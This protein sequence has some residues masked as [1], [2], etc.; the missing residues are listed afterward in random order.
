MPTTISFRSSEGF[1]VCAEEEGHKPLNCTRKFEDNIPQSW[2]TFEL[3]KLGGNKVALKA[4]NGKYVRANEGGNSFLI[5]D[6]D[7]ANA[8]EQF[9]LEDHGGRYALRTSDGYYWCAEGGGGGELH[10][11]RTEVGG[12]WETFTLVSTAVI[13]EPP[14]VGGRLSI[15]GRYFVNDFGLYRWRFV[16]ALS[17]LAKPH[18]QQ[19]EYLDWVVNTGFNGIRVFAGALTWAGQ[20]AAMAVERL[21]RLLE[22][23]QARGLYVEI[24]AITDSKEGGYNVVEHATVIGNIARAFENTTLELANEPFHGTQADALRDIKFLR[25]LS[26]AVPSYVCTAFGASSDDENDEFAEGDYITVH[27]DRGRDKWNQ[28]RRVREMLALSE[29][30]KKPVVNNEPMGA[31]ERDG[32]STG[33]KQRIADPAFFFAMGV[34]NRL[35]EVGGVH[36]STHG[37]NAELP[38]PVQQQCAEAFIRASLLFGNSIV[39][40]KNAGW[41]DSPVESANFEKTVVRAYSGLSE[42]VNLLVLLGLTGDP[43]LRMKNGWQLG[44]VVAEMPGVRVVELVR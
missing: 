41:P 43:E 22:E 14:E 29:A 12:A 27:L 23:A 35:F 11:K 19:I 25:R 20:T 10:T 6:R 1:Y 42:S 36:H 44:S 30:K 17:I 16:S 37:L 33:T 3:V 21:P 40:F 31:D 26:D 8:H 7:E 4:V 18:D 2:E 28:V 34:L 39:T 32:G 5:A 9:D 38:G 15:A 24:T 13:D